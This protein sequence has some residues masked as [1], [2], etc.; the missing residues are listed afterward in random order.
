[1]IRIFILLS[2]L[3]LLILFIGCTTTPDPVYDEPQPAAEETTAEIIYEAIPD[4]NTNAI[5]QLAAALSSHEAVF[6]VT[7]IHLREFT[8]VALAEHAG[9]EPRGM[10]IYRIRYASDG[11]EV[12]GY[13]AAPDDFLEYEYPILV[14]NRGGNRTFGMLSPEALINFALRGYIVLASQYRGVAG[15]T[16]MEQ[17]GGDDINDVLRLIDIS[18]NF[19]FAQQGG[20]Y[21]FGASRGG[22]MTYIASRMDN[23]IVAATVW[24]AISNAFDSFNEREQAMQSVYIDLIG[25]TPEELPEEFERRSAVFWADEINVPLLI[26]HGGDADWRVLTHH[27]I[28]MAEALERYG[29]PHRLIIYPDAGHGGEET[30]FLDE[31][32]QWFRQH[33]IGEG[34]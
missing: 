27:A 3:T 15:G 26:G 18:E 1:M 28:N 9:L 6:E 10:V 30:N 34:S 8:I 29:K 12:I 2:L 21:M 20:V 13:V 22:M 19:M 11:Y 32:D 5:S 24:A 16:G 4:T 14:V 33:P 23:R 25:G 17:F 7:P 31:M